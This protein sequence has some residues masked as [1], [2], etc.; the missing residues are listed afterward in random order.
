MSEMGNEQSSLD[1]RSLVHDDHYYLGS[2]STGIQGKQTPRGM[3]RVIMK[4]F[5]ITGFSG[6]VSRHFI[7]YLDNNEID[8]VIMGV[9]VTKPEF[10]FDEYKKV[11]CTYRELDLLNQDDITKVLR[12]FRPDYI[13]HLASYSSVAYSWK[14]PILS[15]RNNTNIFLNLLQSVCDLGLSC[16]I[17]SIGSSEEYGNVTAE[18]LPLKEDHPLNP[19]SPYAVARVSQE[20]LSRV[21]SSGYHLDV[22]MTRSFNHIGPYQKTIFAIPAFANQLSEAKIRGLDRCD[23]MAGDVDIIR[24]FVD[25]RDVVAAYYALLERGLNG[26]VYNVCSG[27][28]IALKTVIEMMGSLL[29]IKVNIKQSKSLTRPDDNHIIIG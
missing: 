22:V 13:L 28:G 17:L 9:D 20:L 12:Q 21:Y 8:S 25:V 10:Q 3:S 6:F 4:K 27:K 7:D 15:F 16:R 18:D 2:Q 5:L 29:N 19:I 24:D 23:V 14:Q 11:K 1:Y 26:E